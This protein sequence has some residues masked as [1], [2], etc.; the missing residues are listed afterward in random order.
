MKTGIL[1]RIFALQ[2]AIFYRLLAHRY[3]FWLISLLNRESRKSHFDLSLRVK[4][5][6]LSANSTYTGNREEK[7]L[8]IYFLL[9]KNQTFAIFQFSQ[10]CQK[11]KVVC[12][13]RIQWPF[14]YSDREA[15]QRN[16][17]WNCYKF[18]STYIYIRLGLYLRV[19]PI[20]E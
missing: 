14:R 18:L 6:K 9:P 1:C 15:Q 7:R 10:N 11:S 17:L 16:D 5:T 2:F 8:N 20:N 4:L 19:L 12:Q 13:T 3:N